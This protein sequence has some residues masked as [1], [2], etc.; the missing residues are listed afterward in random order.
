MNAIQEGILTKFTKKRLAEREDTKEKLE[1]L[2]TSEKLMKP[3]YNRPQ[4]EY[5]INKF[6][7]LNVKVP[8]QRKALIDTFVNSIY[9]YETI[10]RL[11]ALT[12]K[13][14]LL[15]QALKMLQVTEKSSDLY[16]TGAPSKR[17]ENIG[18]RAFLLCICLCR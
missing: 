14:A 8:E 1:P 7:K 5:W 15:W 16:C 17:L 11:L 6:R 9:L 4:L 13:T 10:R 12:I 18:F 2:I 3:K